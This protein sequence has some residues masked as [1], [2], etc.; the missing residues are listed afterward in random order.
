MKKIE[1]PKTTN[2]RDSNDKQ[3][4]YFIYLLDK[5]KISQI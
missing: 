5:N 4:P 3:M 1:R 2:H